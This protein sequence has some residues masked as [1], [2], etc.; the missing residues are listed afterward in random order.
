M[1]STYT[2]E[3]NDKTIVASVQMDSSGDIFIQMKPQRRYSED[4]MYTLLSELGFHETLD[5][6]KE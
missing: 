6:F 1:S 4:E 3:S 5:P 2:F